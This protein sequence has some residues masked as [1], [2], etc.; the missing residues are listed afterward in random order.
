[1]GQA[2]VAPIAEQHIKTLQLLQSQ[3]IEHTATLRSIEKSLDKAISEHSNKLEL[4]HQELK[5][6]AANEKDKP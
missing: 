4:I 5:R 1:M 3:A 2:G 6:F